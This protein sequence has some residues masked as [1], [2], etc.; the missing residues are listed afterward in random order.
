MMTTLKTGK[1]ALWLPV[2]LALL[3]LS[4]TPAFA[5]SGG[6][7]TS[8][9]GLVV[10]N[11]GGVIPGADVVAKNNGTGFTLQGV[12]NE[13]GRFVIPGVPPARTP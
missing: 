7:S 8:L 12:T 13:A 11:S 1:T 3:V 10:D 4:G 5:Q 6:G 2:I 9:S